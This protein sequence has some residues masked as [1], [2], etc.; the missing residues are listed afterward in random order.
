MFVSDRR[1]PQL[2][3]P[4]RGPWSVHTVRVQ[5][6]N[7]QR[8]TVAVTDRRI[9]SPAVIG[10]SMCTL[11]C[12]GTPASDVADADEDFLRF[13]AAVATNAATPN[14]ARRF[15]GDCRASVT[16]VTTSTY[17]ME[18]HNTP[19]TTTISFC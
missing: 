2:G 17:S 9:P 5:Q 15:V 1:L 14:A 3:W 6:Q 12:R 16:T 13:T 11:G 8:V 19:A 7:R 10:L 4:A 18:L